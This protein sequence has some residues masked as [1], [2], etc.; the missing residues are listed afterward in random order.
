MIL[1]IETLLLLVLVS[2]V[3]ITTL[4][5]QR[6]ARQPQAAPYRRPLAALDVTRAAIGRGAETGRVTHVSPGAGAVGTTAA[7][8]A[9]TGETIAG[10]LVTERVVTE[11]ARN[12]APLVATSG[13]AVTYLALRGMARQAYQRAGQA[14]DYDAARFQLWAQQSPVAYSAAVAA[15]YARETLEASQLIGSFGPEFLLAG[16]SGAQREI[17]QVAG[18]AATTAL[19]LMLLTTPA[20]LI[21]EEIFAAEAYLTAAPA[22]RARLTTHDLVRTLVIILLLAG[23]VYAL[24]QLALGLPPLPGL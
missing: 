1:S 21:G 17:A 16:E 6:R 4:L 20:T 11:A 23:L 5:G 13:D 14:Q 2:I 3:V 8:A 12:G 18:S 19:P 9:T 10:L 24:L 15:V 22:A 7:S